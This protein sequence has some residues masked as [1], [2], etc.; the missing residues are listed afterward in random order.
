M[1]TGVVVMAYGTPRD[2]ADVATF[3]TDV[4]H[5]RPPTPE[6]LADLER[7]YGAIGGISPLNDRTAAQVHALGRALDQLEPGQY[8]VRYGAKHSAPR[9]EEAV[10]QLAADGVDALVGLVLAPHYSKLS[11]GEYV[12]RARAAADD[13]GLA[14]GFVEQWHDDEVLVDVLAERVL[15]AR[16]KIELELA[17]EATSAPAPFPLEVCFTAHSL[18]E[19]I[20]EAG[21]PYPA[22]LAETAA[23]VARRAGLAHHRVGYQSAGRT[24]ERWIGPDIL[25][26]I[27]TLAADGVRGVIVCPAGFTSD[28]LE[29]LYDLDIEARALA[30]ALGMALVRTESLNDDP[31]IAAALARRIAAA[32][33]LPP[34]VKG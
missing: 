30:H 11:V 34:T 32:R 7:R 3:Y 19:R 16:A 31:R 22:Q 27:R 5:G 18:P 25:D 6:L 1:T 15:A 13:A 23:L 9:I 20:L 24:K 21:D 14:S 12:E 2:A 28:H 29:V 4:R 33:P 17:Q 8:R 10:A 26:L